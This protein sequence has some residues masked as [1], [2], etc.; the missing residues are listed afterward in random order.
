M[1]AFRDTNANKG[2]LVPGVW[3]PSHLSRWVSIYIPKV[4]LA[5]ECDH[6]MNML[7]QFL[8][9]GLRLTLSWGE[10]GD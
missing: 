8:R 2:W 1:V 5:K 10:C 7:A 4:Y 6:M 3:S 9:Y